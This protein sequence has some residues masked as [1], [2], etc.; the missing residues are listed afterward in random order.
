MNPIKSLWLLLI[1]LLISSVALYR[2]YYSQP[3][4]AY[5]DLAEVYQSFDYQKQLR[6]QLLRSD[7]QAQ[8]LLDSLEVQLQNQLRGVGQ[9]S[10]AVVEKRLVS[11]RW[12]YAQRQEDL[13]GQQEQL[14]TEFDQQIWKQLD[15]YL[16]DFVDREGYDYVI[17]DR[18][19]G[20]IIG[21]RPAYDCTDEII[22]YVNQR[23]AGLEN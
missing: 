21:G 8:F 2:S 17:G 6:Q 14:A 9:T 10:D 4:T 22:H 13:L 19:D 5:V 12:E 1:C 11:L 16:R 15:Q 7:Q 18:Q 23:Y 20:T 3:R